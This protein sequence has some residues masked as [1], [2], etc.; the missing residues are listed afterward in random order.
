MI[1]T[2]KVAIS[3]KKPSF[4][5]NVAVLKS[6]ENRLRKIKKNDNP[7]V[8]KINIANVLFI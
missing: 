7:T 1:K 5:V 8:N 3:I 6:S 2:K 4:L